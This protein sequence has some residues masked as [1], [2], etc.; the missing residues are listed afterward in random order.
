[1]KVVKNLAD[2]I[3]VKTIVTLTVIAVFATL[4]LKGNINAENVMVVVSTVI[5]FYFGTQHEK[6]TEEET[7]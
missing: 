2:L 3:K 4:A 1:M 7:K 5:A 6:K